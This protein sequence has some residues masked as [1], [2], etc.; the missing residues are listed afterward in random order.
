MGLNPEHGNFARVRFQVQLDNRNPVVEISEEQ[1]FPCN[2]CLLY[3][4]GEQGHKF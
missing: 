2:Y 1:S 4:F 3:D